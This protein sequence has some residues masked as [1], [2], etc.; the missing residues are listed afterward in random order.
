MRLDA[1]VPLEGPGQRT[2]QLIEAPGLL[3]IAV[4]MVQPGLRPLQQGQQCRG[5][6]G[7][8][9]TGWCPGPAGRDAAVAAL[10]V[11]QG[12]QH[13]VAGTGRIDLPADARNRG[14]R[15]GGSDGVLAGH[16]VAAVVI[17]GGSCSVRAVRPIGLV[18]EHHGRAGEQHAIAARRQP[19][20]KAR[21]A[22]AEVGD[23]VHPLHAP[24]GLAGGFVLGVHGLAVPGKNL[25]PGGGG[26]LR[27]AR[28]QRAVEP[29]D[30]QPHDSCQPQASSVCPRQS[31]G[32]AD[33]LT[34]M[35]TASA[36]R[37]RS[38]ATTSA[39]ASNKF[40]GPPAAP[41]ARAGCWCLSSISRR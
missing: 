7:H 19:A 13:V 20:G 8:E 16:L 12:H 29:G 21:R 18:V 34:A 3:D 41:A 31:C 9:G 30:Q 37:R 36:P 39:G 28:R 1:P 38:N 17:P 27:E 22:H 10:P 24:P 32:R 2:G 35:R 33:R 5:G 26:R 15:V 11:V 4:E 6:V 25:V 14:A 23:R 40:T